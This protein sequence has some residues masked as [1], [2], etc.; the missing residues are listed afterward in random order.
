MM[1]SLTAL[2]CAILIQGQ[3]S[4]QVF[5]LGGCPD[6]PVKQNFEVQRVSTTETCS[7]FF[8]FLLTCQLTK[9]CSTLAV[10]MNI[11][12]ISPFSNCLVIA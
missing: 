2:L 7:I 3:A 8:C 6:F 12:T 9:S 11:R 10:G 4:A 5:S 1:K